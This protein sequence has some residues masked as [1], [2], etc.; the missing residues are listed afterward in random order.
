MD[1]TRLPRLPAS[2]EEARAAI[3]KIKALLAEKMTPP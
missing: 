1:A 3:A 2:P